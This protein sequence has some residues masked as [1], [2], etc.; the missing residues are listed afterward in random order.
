MVTATAL[1]FLSL[2]QYCAA[3]CNDKN[4]SPKIMRNYFVKLAKFMGIRSSVVD[5]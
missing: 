2:K 4:L 3:I 1:L 5:L